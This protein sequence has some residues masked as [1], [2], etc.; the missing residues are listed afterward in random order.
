ME[1]GKRKWVVGTGMDEYG[2]GQR[3]KDR[4]ENGSTGTGDRSNKRDSD[5]HGGERLVQ[6][7]LSASKKLQACALHLFTK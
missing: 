2:A 3:R 4:K 6:L 7:Y 5:A 1:S